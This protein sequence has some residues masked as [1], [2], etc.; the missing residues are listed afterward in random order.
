M[1]SCTWRALSSAILFFF[2]IKKE[3]ENPPCFKT[4]YV[5]LWKCSVRQVDDNTEFIFFFF[6]A[7]IQSGV[8][9]SE[10]LCIRFVCLCIL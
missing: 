3:L 8:D 10:L 7:K 6:F 4:P 2:L 1:N 9:L 5:C